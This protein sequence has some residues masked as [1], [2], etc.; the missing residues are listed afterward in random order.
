MMLARQWIALHELVKLVGGHPLVKEWRGSFKNMRRCILMGARQIPEVLTKPYKDMPTLDAKVKV[1]FEFV[2][3]ILV[4]VI[5]AFV[6]MV[7]QTETMQHSKYG[8]LR[9]RKPTTRSSARNGFVAW[10]KNMIST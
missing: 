6:P 7:V 10:K 2:I 9:H 4:L 5:L 8:L 3:Q 1:R